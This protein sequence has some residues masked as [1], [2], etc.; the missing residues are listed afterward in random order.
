MCTCGNPAI[1]RIANART[2]DQRSLILLSDGSIVHWSGAEIL[3]IPLPRNSRKPEKRAEAVTIGRMFMGEVCLYN[4][5][6]LAELYK[7]CVWAVK[8]NLGIE[9]AR[10]RFHSRAA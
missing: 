10:A 8:R 1:H 9:G 2:F 6:E 4:Y 5:A 7:A 3:G